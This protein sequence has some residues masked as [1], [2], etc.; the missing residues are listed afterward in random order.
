MGPGP[1]YPIEYEMTEAQAE[2]LVILLVVFGVVLVGVALWEWRSR[3]LS[4]R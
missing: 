2:R 3:R 4:K 1:F